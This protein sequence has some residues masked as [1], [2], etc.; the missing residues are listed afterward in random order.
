MTRDYEG[1]AERLEAMHWMDCHEAV[2]AI[3][4]LVR[5]RD[6]AERETVEKIVAW[7]RSMGLRNMNYVAEDIEAGEWKR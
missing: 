4:E 7:M 2:A 3:R 5:E 6:E 1:L